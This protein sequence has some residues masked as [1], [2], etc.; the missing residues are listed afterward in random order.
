[1]PVGRNEGEY[2]LLL[3]G[4]S[5]VIH[6]PQFTRACRWGSARLV[7]SH[8]ICGTTPALK[9]SLP[10]YSL[11]ESCGIYNCALGPAPSGH[12]SKRR[13]RR[14]TRR[15]AS[16]PTDEVYITGTRVDRGM[17][18]RYLQLLF[19]AESEPLVLVLAKTIRDD[20]IDVSR[21]ERPCS[22][23]LSEAIQLW[24]NLM[25]AERRS[26]RISSDD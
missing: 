11:C 24:P 16:D 9:A 21:I 22:L 2:R 12:P 23:T 17:I 1:M 13:S 8:E 3:Q 10:V 25:T 26:I 20:R 4:S 7:S 15:T 18:R 19:D 14:E 6:S 5:D